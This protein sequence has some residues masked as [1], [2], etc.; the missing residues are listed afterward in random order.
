MTDLEL[1]IKI[2]E[3]FL[4]DPEYAYNYHYFERKTGESRERIKKVMD[5]LRA[6]GNGAMVKYVKGLISEDGE[7]M[8]SGFE[9]TTRA[10]QW[11]IR[12][13]LE[14]LKKIAQLDKDK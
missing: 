1:K 14:E 7:L 2:I 10:T 11:S 4:E 9:L 6:G 13:W 3:G 8:G 12:E 5:E